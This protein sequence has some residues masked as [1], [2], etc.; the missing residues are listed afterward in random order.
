MK[1]WREKLKWLNIKIIAILLIITITITSNENFVNAI[2]IKAKQ[3][4]DSTKLTTE[5]LNERENN[6]N[7]ESEKTRN[8]L[9]E[10]ISKRK[11]NEKTFFMSDGSSLVTVYPSNVHYEENGKLEEIDNRL[12]ENGENI[13]NNQGPYSIQYSK[14]ILEDCEIGKIKKGQNEIKWKF[15]GNERKNKI[16]NIQNE[17]K[18]Q[19]G[20]LTE[21]IIKEIQNNSTKKETKINKVKAK[22]KNPKVKNEKNKKLNILYNSENADIIEQENVFSQI[23]Y[24]N[25]LDNTDLEY[26]NT[27]DSVKESIIIKNKE[28]VQEKYVF[29]YEVNNM[30]MSLN[31]DKEILVTSENTDEVIYKIEAPYMFDNKLEQST[32]IEVNLIDED[33]RYIVEII[34]SKDWIEAKE[35]EYPITIDPTINTSLDYGNIQD[36][37]IFKGDSRTPNRHKAHIIRI[38]SNNRLKNPPRGLIKFNLPELRAG[39]QVIAAMLDI[40]NYPDT[41]EW[42]PSQNEM[43]INVHKMTA[44]WNEEWASWDNCNLLNIIILIL[45]L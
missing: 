21:N 10:D 22:I 18:T 26:S 44:D 20:I 34:P 24:E 6:R 13:Q 9:G 8:I 19:N 1:K 36:T 28:S 3:N 11:L 41:E 15:I 32:D 7:K 31:E 27:A 14:E 25:I 5:E 29:E 45:H 2:S 35:R 17:D 42:T 37:F 39:D 30:K 12:T 43:Q 23:Q 16:N 40:C 33:N 38:G 4:K